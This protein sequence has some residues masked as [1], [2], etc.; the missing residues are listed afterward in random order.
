M[1]SQRVRELGDTYQFYARIYA[2]VAVL[3]SLALGWALSRQ[4]TCDLAGSAVECSTSSDGPTFAVVAVVALIG[5][6][7]LLLPVYGIAKVLLVLSGDDAD[8][9]T[10]ARR[11]RTQP[12][13][14]P[15]RQPPDERQPGEV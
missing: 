14:V 8:T 10:V 3:T 12:D 9:G 7:L 5:Q 1:T 2:G 11:A 13:R 4:T 15:K 6:A